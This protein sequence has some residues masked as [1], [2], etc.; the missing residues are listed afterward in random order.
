LTDPNDEQ[1]N[2]VLTRAAEDLGVMMFAGD[3]E[4]AQE[5]EGFA[6]LDDKILSAFEGTLQDRDEESES[7]WEPS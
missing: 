2:S 6:Q 3:G 1:L 5:E 7:D 4:V